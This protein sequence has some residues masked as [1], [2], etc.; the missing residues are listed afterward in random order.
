MKALIQQQN[1][2]RKRNLLLSLLLSGQINFSEKAND[3]EPE[4]VP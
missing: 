3:L 2:R 4:K 1:L